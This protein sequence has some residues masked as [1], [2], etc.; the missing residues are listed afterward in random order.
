[1]TPRELAWEYAAAQQRRDD[2]RDRQIVLAWEIERVRILSA[3]NAHR[4]QPMPSL[5]QVLQ[6]RAVRQT[7][8]EMRNTLAM[9]AEQYGF[10][11][12]KTVH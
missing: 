12:K 2:D 8:T 6:K 4:Q 10:P 1:M 11:L 7:P 5:K 3:N 9:M